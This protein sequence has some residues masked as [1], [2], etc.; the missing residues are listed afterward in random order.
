MKYKLLIM[1]IINCS[2]LYNSIHNMLLRGKCHD[3]IPIL[4]G[5]NLTALIKKMG[6][7]RPVAVGYYRRKLAA[8][9]ANTHPSNRLLDFFL[10]IQLNVGVSG[11]YKVAVHA[12]QRYVAK[13]QKIMS[14]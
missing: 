2:L 11:K 1:I 10:P 8:T 6:N 9:Y 14:M 3:I 7:I 5:G 12:C 13:C 4:F